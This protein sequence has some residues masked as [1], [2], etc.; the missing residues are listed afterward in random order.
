MAKRSKKSSKEIF[1]VG[2][3]DT[4]SIKSRSSFSLLNKELCNFLL[5]KQKEGAEIVLFTR[6]HKLDWFKKTEEKQFSIPITAIIEQCFNL[7]ITHVLTV[8]DPVYEAFKKKDISGQPYKLGEYY[9]QT[10]L[11]STTLESFERFTHL[12]NQSEALFEIR[13]LYNLEKKC[14]KRNM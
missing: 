4:L 13:Q 11:G 2:I 12:Q 1:F 6:R 8:L 3:D 14:F 9:N 5:A 10:T 7:N